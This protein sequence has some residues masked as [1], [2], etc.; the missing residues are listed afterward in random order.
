MGW[1]WRNPEFICPLSMLRL[2]KFFSPDPYVIPL[3]LEKYI[4]RF[5]ESASKSDLTLSISSKYLSELCFT[6]E[7]SANVYN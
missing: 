7:V 4:Q 5:M 6:R 3:H 2:W 1:T